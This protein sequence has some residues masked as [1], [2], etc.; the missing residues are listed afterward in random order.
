MDKT[1]KV[2]AGISSTVLMLG[3]VGCGSELETAPLPED[4]YCTEWEWDYDDGVWEC[5]DF[6]SHYYGHSYYGGRYFKT[7]SDLYKSKDY[8]AYKNSSS[9]L[10]SSVTDSSIKKSSGFGSGVKSFGG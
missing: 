4:S 1:K 7:K 5:D 10:G 6:D 3:L 9:F 2:M 8:M